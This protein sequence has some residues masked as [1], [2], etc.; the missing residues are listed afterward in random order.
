VPWSLIPPPTLGLPDAEID[1]TVHTGSLPCG[2]WGRKEKE[3]REEKEE[4][5]REERREEKKK[6]K[7]GEKK[8]GA[9]Q[10]AS[11]NELTLGLSPPSP[12]PLPPL[13]EGVGQEGAPMFQVGS[14]DS[15]PYRNQAP[16]T[17][18]EPLSLPPRTLSQP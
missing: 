4:R 7:K 13:S 15:T 17:L 1:K 14:T 6:E 8:E 5:R 3:R 12:I 11:Y 2:S 16:K 18:L 9:A 10:A